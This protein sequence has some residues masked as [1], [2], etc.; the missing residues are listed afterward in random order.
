MK[1]YIRTRDGTIELNKEEIERVIIAQADNI[2]ELIRD[3]DIL[4]IYDL[5][6]DAVL[7]VEGNIKPFG[8][9][10]AIKLKKWLH[11]SPNKFYL[12][13]KDSKGN[14]I[15]RAKTNYKGKLELL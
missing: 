1:K 4:Y 6:P 12:Y 9:P 10:S 13:T 7:V 15:K 2:E 8:Y 11:Y 14:Y 5:Y 3:D